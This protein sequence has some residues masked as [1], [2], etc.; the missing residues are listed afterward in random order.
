MQEMKETW[1][2]SVGWED[3]LQEGMTTHSRIL[4]WKV[5]WQRS[6]EGYSP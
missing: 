1:I 2:Q 6:L 5:L 3:P 4:A